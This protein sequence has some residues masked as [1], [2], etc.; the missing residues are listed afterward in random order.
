MK[1]VGWI[2][3]VMIMSGVAPLVAQNPPA[4]P[5]PPSRDTADGFE[6]AMRGMMGDPQRMQQM[7]MQVEERFGRMVQSELQL[8]EQQ[9]TQLR[10]AMRANQDRRRDLMRREMDLR[11]AVDTQLT[12]GVAANNDSLTRMMNQL[13]QLRVQQ[14]Q[15]DDQFQRDL[16]FLTP[17]QKARFLRMSQRLQE[18]MQEVRRRTMEDRQDRQDRHEHRDGRPMDGQPPRDRQPGERRPMDDRPRRDLQL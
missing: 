6:P 12:P 13:S 10:T 8:N 9:M 3:A 17:V 2:A 7:R 4:A 16:G 5:P 18:R 15:S 14:A 1:R 11:R